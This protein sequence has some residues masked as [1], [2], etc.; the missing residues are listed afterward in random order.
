MNSATI[1]DWAVDDRP[2]EK[3]LYKGIQSL[4]NSELLAILLNSGIQNKS[5]VELAKELLAAVDNDLQRLG[6]LSVQDIIKLKI[7][8]IGPARAVSIAAALELGVR[9]DAYQIQGKKMTHSRDAANFLKSV[10]QY[11]KQEA[12]AVIFLTGTNRVKH[13]EL[14]SEGG[15][16][17]TV[18]DPRVILRKALEH[19]AINLILCHNHPSGDIHP[20]KMD[21][22]LTH[23]IANAAGAL[24]ITVVDHIIVGESG[25]FSFADQGLM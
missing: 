15:L 12:F 25:Y 20:S 13:F 5:A 16:A 23:K 22:M 6:K 2:R 19:D 18:A 11:R 3:L 1:K 24:D 14:I 7:K 8:G 4:S 17:G 9:R 21:E 10:L